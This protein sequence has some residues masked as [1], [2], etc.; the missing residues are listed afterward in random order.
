MTNIVVGGL[1]LWNKQRIKYS[2]IHDASGKLLAFKV[3]IYCEPLKITLT[4]KF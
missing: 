1:D 4:T 3:K 2:M